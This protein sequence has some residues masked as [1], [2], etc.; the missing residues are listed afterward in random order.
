LS[1][2]NKYIINIEISKNE[3]WML[4]GWARS[5]DIGFPHSIILR[6]I[7]NTLI[8]KVNLLAAEV[9]NEHYQKL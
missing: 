5:R 6:R 4:I 1:R 3:T 8:V 2:N 7:E 9:D